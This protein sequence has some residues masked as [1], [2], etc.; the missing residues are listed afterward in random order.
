MPQ[1]TRLFGL[2]EWRMKQGGGM[3]VAEQALTFLYKQYG[4]NDKIPC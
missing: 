2:S 3:R 4:K 1:R